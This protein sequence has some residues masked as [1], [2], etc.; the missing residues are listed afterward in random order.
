M[1][2]AESLR[3]RA[4]MHIAASSPAFGEAC[5]RASRIASSACF[6]VASCSSIRNAATSAT[7]RDCPLWQCTARQRKANMNTLDHSAE[8]SMK[9]CSQPVSSE[10]V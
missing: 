5:G 1:V 2:Q 9:Y 7:L 3:H 8:G 4:L 10:Q 6:R